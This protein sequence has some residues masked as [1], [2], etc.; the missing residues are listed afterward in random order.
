MTSTG[1]RT[2][3]ERLAEDLDAAFP[4]LLD[5]YGGAVAT[6]ARRAC[7]AGDGAD[8]LTAET[9]LRAWVALRGYEPARIAA[10]DLRPWLLTICLNQ[11]RND[12]RRASRR[13]RT[14]PFD[15]AAPGRGPYS[16]SPEDVAVRRDGAGALGALLARLPEPQR[17]A[18]VLR[19]VVGCSAAEIAS[20]L[21]C[22]EGTARS[23]V[24]RGLERLRTLAPEVDR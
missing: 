5:A 18:V 17:V 16:P 11:A 10:L 23:H 15:G 12:R 6:T 8:D 19:H 24:S 22:A 2:L 21:G 7:A 3:A 13:P 14:A 9:F 1:G 4:D 20:V